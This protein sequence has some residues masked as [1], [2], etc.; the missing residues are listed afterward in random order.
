M[1]KKCQHKLVEEILGTKADTW[2]KEVKAGENE[3]PSYIMH[4]YF[5]LYDMLNEERDA[6]LKYE[7][8]IRNL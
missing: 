3:L 5:A 7:E 1:G 6:I 2:Y 8:E 4:S